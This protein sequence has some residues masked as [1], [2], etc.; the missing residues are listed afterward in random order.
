MIVFFSLKNHTGIIFQRYFPHFKTN[1]L[2]QLHPQDLLNNF[3]SF[4]KIHKT[5]PPPRTTAF[6]SN[7]EG[8]LKKIRVIF[9]IIFSQQ[10]LQKFKNF[11]LDF[12]VRMV[13]LHLPKPRISSQPRLHPKRWRVQW[14]DQGI[15]QLRLK[16]LST[17]TQSK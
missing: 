15:S 1:Q 12:V 6:P 9:V 2:P 3:K 5:G 16:R 7:Y 14:S 13:R 10:K 8:R 17:P 4:R 11:S